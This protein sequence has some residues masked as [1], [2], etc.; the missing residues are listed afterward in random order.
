MKAAAQAV[1]LLVRVAP[2]LCVIVTSRELLRIG[3][4]RGYPVPPLDV[5]SGVES[6]PGIKDGDRMRFFV[7]EVR[8]ADCHTDAEADP[9]AGEGCKTCD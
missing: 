8:R 4:E 1:A 9:D 3:G 6:A 2:K 7:E 5:A